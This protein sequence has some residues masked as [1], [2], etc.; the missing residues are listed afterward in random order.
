MTSKDGICFPDTEIRELLSSS[1]SRHT[2]SQ[3]C[4]EEVDNQR[5]SQRT[6][7]ASLANT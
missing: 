4:V 2:Y 5:A 1:V 3:Y 6:L 7:E